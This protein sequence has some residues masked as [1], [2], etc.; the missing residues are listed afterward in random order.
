MD[1]N[2]TRR[3]CSEKYISNNV[4]TIVVFYIVL[5]IVMK[6]QHF[7]TNLQFELFIVS[8]AAIHQ[9]HIL[10]VMSPLCKPYVACG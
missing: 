6:N 9:T 2:A 7:L 4:F 8:D 5:E 3:K 10:P 1:L